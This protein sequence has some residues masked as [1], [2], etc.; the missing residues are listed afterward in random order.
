MN[1]NKPMLDRAQELK[2]KWNPDQPKGMK[3]DPLKP[4]VKSYLVSVAKNVGLDVSSGSLEVDAC[5]DHI[6]SLEKERG[7][8]FAKDCAT[9][10][11]S[12][13]LDDSYDQTESD[14]SHVNLD[15]GSCSTFF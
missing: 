4:L 15:E 10:K 2:R 7:S 14:K 8:S 12:I 6:E 1:N 3:P 11:L 5:F 9:C 13:V